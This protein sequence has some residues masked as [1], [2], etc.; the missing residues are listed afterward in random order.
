[1]SLIYGH[2]GAS[3][4]AP[5]NTLEAF[6]LSMDMGADGFELDVHMSADG[7]LV[8][9]HDESVDRTTNG[10][11]LVKDLTLAQLKQLDASAGMDEY[12][13]AKIPTLSEVFDLV[14]D[15]HHI[16]NVEIKT[17]ECFYPEIE[18]KCL[19][20]AKE[21]GVE[22][23]IIYSSFNHFTL[24]RMRELKP[25][26]KLGMLFGDILIKPWEYAKSLT[27]DYV[28]PMK[29][30]IY[31]PDFIEEAADNNLGIN[32]WTINDEETMLRCLNCGAGVITNYPDIAIKL[33]DENK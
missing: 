1:M 18:E 33:R 30:N 24:L 25:D 3:G 2:R 31:V 13:G 23:R 5:E 11:G 6:R 17:D 4:Y 8:V 32:M 29:M 12:K 27:V 20:L 21:K 22:D 9:I 28:H 19:A 15:T 7:E 26:V 10:T 16:V 14:R